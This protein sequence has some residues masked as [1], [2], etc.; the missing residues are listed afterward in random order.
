LE[1]GSWFNK[2]RRKWRLSRPLCNAFE[3]FSSFLSVILTEERLL[4]FQT[5]AEQLCVRHAW[6]GRTLLAGEVNPVLAV[7]AIDKTF[8]NFGCDLAQ[9]PDIHTITTAG[10]GCPAAFGNLKIYGVS[11]AGRDGRNDGDVKCLRPGSRVVF[12]VRTLLGNNIGVVALNILKKMTAS[13][14]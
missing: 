9:V 3:S 1:I 12:A 5:Q 2:C 14:G 8:G 13:S 11:A 7:H 10:G 6:L 4:H